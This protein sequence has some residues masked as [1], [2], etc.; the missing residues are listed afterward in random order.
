MYTL[1]ST[2][3]STCTSPLTC[4]R[5]YIQLSECYQSATTMTDCCLLVCCRPRTFSRLVGDIYPKGSTG[6]E[7]DLAPNKLQRLCAY[8]AAYPGKAE[9]ICGQLL[10]DMAES[11]VKGKFGYTKITADAFVGLVGIAYTTDVS[12]VIEPFHRKA[13]SLLL[14]CSDYPIHGVALTLLSAYTRQNDGCAAASFVEAVLDICNRG[15]A[16][17]S[18]NADEQSVGLEMLLRIIEALLSNPGIIEQYCAG[19]AAICCH[20]LSVQRVCFST[21]DASSSGVPRSPAVLATQCLVVLGSV[22]SPRTLACIFTA[23]FAKFDNNFWEPIAPPIKAIDLVLSSSIFLNRF[24]FPLCSLLISHARVIATNVMTWSDQ[25]KLD[26]FLGV[27]LE[28]KEANSIGSENAIRTVSVRAKA[29]LS[30]LTVAETLS[31]RMQSISGVKAKDNLIFFNCMSLEQDCKHLLELLFFCSLHSGGQNFDETQLPHNSI[32]C[33]ESTGK[34]HLLTSALVASPVCEVQSSEIISTAHDENILHNISQ[35]C[36][37]LLYFVFSTSCTNRRSTVAP[38]SGVFLHMPLSNLFSYVRNLSDRFPFLSSRFRNGNEDE[39][40]GCSIAMS[41]QQTALHAINMALC[42]C[43]KSIC[44]AKSTLSESVSSGYEYIFPQFSDDN[45]PDFASAVGRE[46]LQIIFAALDSPSFS[47]YRLAASSIIHLIAVLFSTK[48][49]SNVHSLSSC[50]P[51]VLSLHAL[52][53]L[54]CQE[55]SI[56]TMLSC[57]YKMMFRD[58]TVFDEISHSEKVATS[59]LIQV[60]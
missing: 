38:V 5:Y 3:S 58:L 1:G 20:Y 57:L 21:G 37:R 29:I 23:L 14:S 47:L 53:P 22:S 26:S 51:P 46:G 39:Y 48:T 49:T 34:K 25:A 19:I 12:F 42:A 36:L 35:H 27:I 41:M 44:P 24:Y 32:V 10:K 50:K 13:L 33:L 59:W 17:N 28:E 45:F 8:A 30:I 7:R 55:F 4:Q 18:S 15:I 11:I 56:E 16:N 60:L 6:Y 9:F 40:L 43:S 54:K 2:S 52:N 31:A